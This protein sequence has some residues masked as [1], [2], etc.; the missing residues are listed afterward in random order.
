[1]LIFSTWIQA[2]RTGSLAAAV[3]EAMTLSFPSAGSVAREAT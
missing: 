3:A 1:M 2:P